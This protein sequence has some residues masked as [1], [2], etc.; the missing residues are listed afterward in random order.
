MPAVVDAIVG[1]FDPVKVVLF[2]SVANGTEGPDS[3]IDLLVVFDELAIHER[4]PILSELIST[5]AIGPPVDPIPIDLGDL[6]T[7]GKV[8]GMVRTALREGRVLHERH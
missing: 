1:R 3:D 2:G 4:L 6:A 5:T 7:Q 8:P